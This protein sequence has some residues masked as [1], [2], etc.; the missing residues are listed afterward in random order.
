MNFCCA[1]SCARLNAAA[2]SSRSAW[3][4]ARLARAT[5]TCAAAWSRAAATSRFSS[6]AITSPS[7]TRCPSCTPSHSRRPVPFDDTDARRAATTRPVAFRT[8]IDADG[9]A[10]ATV[11]ISTDCGALRRLT[12]AQAPPA[13]RAQSPTPTIASRVGG[14]DAA[15]Q[16]RGRSPSVRAMARWERFDLASESRDLDR[17]PRSRG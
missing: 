16:R 15:R 10:A 17:E 1:R 5:C 2:A 8:E 13:A 3:P 6:R 9:Y 7:L 14:D 4:W 11:A 12:K